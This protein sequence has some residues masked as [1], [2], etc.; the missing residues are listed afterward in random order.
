[1][2]NKLVSI[3]AVF[4]MLSFFGYQAEAQDDPDPGE[5]SGG[6]CGTPDESGGGGG[7]GCGCGCGSILIA[8]TDL[9]DTYQYADDYDDDG[10]EDD[11]DNCPFLANR[12]QADSDGDAV[13]DSCDNCQNTS[14]E[15]Q[16]NVDGDGVGDVCD[17]DIDN[18]GIVNGQDNCQFVPNNTQANTDQDAF[19]DACDQDIDQDGID[20][21]E[22]NCPFAFNPDQLDTDPDALG[23][24]CD[25]DTDNDMISDATDNCPLVQ[26]PDQLDLDGDLMG[27]ECDV[28]MDD[29]GILNKADNC[30]TVAD[31]SQKDGDRDGAGD[32]CDSSYCYVVDDIESCLDPTSTFSVYA[33]VDRTV[34]TS[35]KMP[36]LLWA[37]RAN[38]AIRYEWTIVTRPNKSS[39]TIRFLP[40]HWLS[41]S[42]HQGELDRP[43]LNHLGNRSL[44]LLP[45]S[46]GAQKHQTHFQIAY[47]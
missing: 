40:S 43:H 11:F 24:A 47:W 32:V 10:I 6:L 21:F 37:N 38:R 23:D 25:N 3:V 20:N 19:G 36:L 13:G 12:D 1:M 39:A 28:D 35:E 5:C 30:P 7:C 46:P 16:A 44:N 17:P 14:N 9:G 2:F 34:Q 15:N 29:D 8:N 18:D 41:L 26:N 42:Y 45:I 33:G 22:D 4:L 27:N 31:D